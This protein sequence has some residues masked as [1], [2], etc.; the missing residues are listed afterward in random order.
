MRDVASGHEEVAVPDARDAGARPGADRHPAVNGDVFAERVPVADL[1]AG[2]FALVAEVLWRAAED[3]AGAD[4]VV[5]A[6][7]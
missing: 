6:R 4:I 1:D 2:D 3:G 5:G 7:P